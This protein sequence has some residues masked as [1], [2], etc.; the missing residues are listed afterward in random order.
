MII[1]LSI[2]YAKKWEQIDNGSMILLLF[3]KLFSQKSS[4]PNLKEKVYFNIPKYI[5]SK[6]N[7]YQSHL[8]K[9][10]NKYKTFK[11]KYDQVNNTQITNDQKTKINSL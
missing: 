8:E 3:K 6:N 5:S 2:S 10:Q 7:H 11:R 4:Q 9:K 1:Y